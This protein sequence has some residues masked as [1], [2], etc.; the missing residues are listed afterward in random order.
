MKRR[1]SKGIRRED[2]SRSA[3]EEIRWPGGS[4]AL[5]CE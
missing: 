2:S 4:D 3:T 1:E 5:R